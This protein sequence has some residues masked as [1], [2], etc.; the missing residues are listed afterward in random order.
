MMANDGGTHA[1]ESVLSLLGEA[2]GGDEHVGGHACHSEEPYL[3][4]DS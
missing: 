2:G 4:T 3:D 1:P